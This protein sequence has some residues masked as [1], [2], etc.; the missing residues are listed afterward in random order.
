MALAVASPAPAPAPAPAPKPGVIATSYTAPLV[1]SAPLAYSAY[2]SYRYPPLA[3]SA[4]AAAPLA[5]PYA[6][7]GAQTLVY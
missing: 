1:A 4:Y 6:Y 5:Y 2:N 7:P 3:Y